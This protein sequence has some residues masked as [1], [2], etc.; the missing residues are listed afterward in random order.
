VDRTKPIV[1]SRWPDRREVVE[2]E[3]CPGDHEL[4]GARASHPGARL[5][6][7]GQ[8]AATLEQVQSV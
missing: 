1:A 7:A 4:L 5:V 3:L 2:R 6:A 8:Q